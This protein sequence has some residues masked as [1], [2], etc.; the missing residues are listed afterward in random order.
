[1]YFL[2]ERRV[3]VVRIQTFGAQLRPSINGTIVANL[4]KF[5]ITAQAI[6]FRGYA[7]MGVERGKRR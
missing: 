1:M 2:N 3:M 6:P 5:V 4:A 7:S